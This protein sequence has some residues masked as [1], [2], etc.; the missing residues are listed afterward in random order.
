M[1]ADLLELQHCI[2]CLSGALLKLLG[3]YTFSCK[4]STADFLAKLSTQVVHMAVLFLGEN[5]RIKLS[6]LIY[7][8]TCFNGSKFANLSMMFL[9]PV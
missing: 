4:D 7:F 2:Q 6:D 3:K 9:I 8:G 1:V 5:H